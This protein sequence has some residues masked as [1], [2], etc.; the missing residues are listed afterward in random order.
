MNAVTEFYKHAE[1][2]V[3]I[4]YI[5]RNHLNKKYKKQQKMKYE[6]D[7]DKKDKDDNDCSK[8]IF[9][10]YQTS[11]LFLVCF[12]ISIFYNSTKNP[13]ISGVELFLRGIL[14]GLFGFIYLL[15]V[16]IDKDSR[17]WLLSLVNIP[18]L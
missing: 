2:T 18:K 11:V 17:E 3:P 13:K 15:W 7:E 6:D 9:I 4:I 12:F 5:Q 8:N 10:N 14:A 1:N 16:L